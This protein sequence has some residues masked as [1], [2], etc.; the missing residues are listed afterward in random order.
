MSMTLAA[1]LWSLLSGAHAADMLEETRGVVGRDMV[2]PSGTA[3]AEALIDSGQ[4]DK[5]LIA[6]QG[7]ALINKDP[8]AAMWAIVCAVRAGDPEAAQA[9]TFMAMDI[10]E[11]DPR[12][13][14]TAAW[15][16]NEG[17]AH[18]EAAK[19]VQDYPE[20]APDAEGALI[21]QMRAWMM[22]GKIRKS[23]RLRRQMMQASQLDAWFWFEIGLEDAWRKQ[24][25]AL[26]HMRQ[27]VRAS[28]AGP[29]HY[30]LLVQYLS[31][32]GRAQEAV[33]TGM[34]GMQ[35]FPSSGQLGLTVLE[36]SQHS[37]G[38]VALEDMLAE[39]PD[40]ARAQ[41]MLGM[42]LLADGEPVDALPHL[43]VAVEEG[44]DR[45]AM[46]LLLA[47]AHLAAD[48]PEASWDSLASG[49]TAHPEDTSLWRELFGLSDAVS[50]QGDSLALYED[51]W[52]QGVHK[53]FLVDLAYQ[54]ASD[55]D[56]LE[57]A[58]QWS[59]RG[60]GI[61]GHSWQGLSQRALVLT[62]LERGAEALTAY[63]EA[64]QIEPREPML[65]NNLAWFLL[66]PSG[67]VEP[68]PV[69]ARSLAEAAVQ[70]AE[71]PQPAYLDTLARALWEQG[72]RRRAIELQRQAAALDP[73]NEHIRNTLQQYETSE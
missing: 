4:W 68:D 28:N 31:D 11:G 16:L 44:E 38:R 55:I 67:D 22:A 61:P 32:Q 45:P 12:I 39:Q 63:E 49:V 56:E 19:L 7:L 23:L 2:L 69:R 33:V 9:A 51:A 62:R 41:A 3:W 40:H 73:E 66:E 65:L 29:A 48:Q 24:P 42:V 27:S 72:E 14:L 36:L 8:D 60:L 46:Y 43:N 15:L 57:L 26:D 10:A 58:L 18:R 53:T 54:A 34:E 50:R 64:L 25:E 1:L 70:H 35:R 37:A 59:D 6:W 13:L 21:M 20:A 17:G 30:Q 52:Q 5:A 71:Q 47:E